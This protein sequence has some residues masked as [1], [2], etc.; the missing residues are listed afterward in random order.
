MERG[1]QVKGDL[2]TDK[3]FIT[4]QKHSG[5][6]FTAVLAGCMLS[7]VMFVVGL[8]LGA[9]SGVTSERCVRAGG[10]VQ[11]DGTC[12]KVTIEKIQVER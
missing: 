9:A 10:I 11:K 12:A 7:L 1:A 8:K 2:M 5:R 6:M 3:E 4:Q